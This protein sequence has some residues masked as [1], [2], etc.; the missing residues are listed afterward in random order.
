MPIRVRCECGKVLN[1]P[2]AAKGKAI[3]CPDC[4]ERVRVPA[5]Q[6][7]K[8]KKKK[9]VA[10]SIDDDDFFGSLDTNDFEDTDTRICPKCATEVEEEDIDCPE[11][12]V[13]IETGV[14]SAK[15]RKRRKQR[16]VDPTE[17]YEVAWKESLAFLKAQKKL[18]IRT[19]VIWTVCSIMFAAASYMANYCE[20]PP[21]VAFWFAIAMVF[22]LCI[23]GWLWH[24]FQ[25][26]TKAG[27]EKREEIGRMP[28]DFFTS[29]SMG[30]KFFAWPYV[31]CGPLNSLIIVA[32]IM[33][34]AATM[35]AGVISPPPVVEA[36]A[37]EQA[38]PNAADPAA[39]NDPN[40]A[41]EAEAA[42]LANTISAAAFVPLFASAGGLFLLPL[43]AFPIA[44]SHMATKYTYKAW[45]PFDMIKL[46]FKN[47]GAV[48]YFWMIAFA[49]LLPA[50]L[51]VVLVGVFNGPIFGWLISL[52][53]KI[54]TATMGADA[55]GFLAF[56]VNAGVWFVIAF[57]F[58]T[59]LSF[60]AAFPSVLLM[61][62]NGLFA[63][64]NKKNFEFVTKTMHGEP[65]GFWVRYLAYLADVAI[66]FGIFTAISIVLGVVAGF[67][68]SMMDEEPLVL[69]ATMVGHVGRVYWLL[70]V[71][72]YFGMTESGISGATM[73]K[74]A[75]GVMVIDKEGKKISKGTAFARAICRG[76]SALPFCGGFIMA[77]FGK[78]QALH[79]M[80]TKTQVVWKGDR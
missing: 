33:G 72:L 42:A 60:M 62:M 75:L 30:I 51:T 59:P 26:I 34:G 11:C 41:V 63:F 19:G 7:K 13:N 9:R 46:V 44:T 69:W 3:R 74:Q 52:N 40:A 78:K 37:D 10:K 53:E 55:E 24:C 28:F 45:L 1:A 77:A 4:G 76:F 21:L 32:A 57:L 70:G 50:I 58:L 39:V 71:F 5:A 61:R 47:I 12:G 43:I 18:A 73:G 15:Q 64:Y 22:Q 66:L 23:P 49:L 20:K 2:D 68:A 25:V 56:M 8:K 29:A 36:A 38:D 54:L 79:D 35:V 16:G 67:G 6:R 65:C 17:F 27:L 14:L 80:M 48:S 31:L